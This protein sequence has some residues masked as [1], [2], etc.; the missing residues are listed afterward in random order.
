MAVD[1]TT[2]TPVVRLD[3]DG[4]RHHD[5]LA[6]TVEGMVATIG[7][8]GATI[9]LRRVVAEQL[10]ECRCSE[11]RAVRK[12]IRQR[13]GHHPRDNTPIVVVSG[14]GVVEA[15]GQASASGREVRRDGAK[16]VGRNGLVRAGY[17]PSTR[18]YAVSVDVVFALFGMAGLLPKES[19]VEAGK[20]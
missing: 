17:R 15:E 5:V 6:A 10:I 2:L 12:Y 9:V 4:H 18:H 7:E 20:L 11:G 19:T 14:K 8:C 1:V 3:P 13:L 16:H